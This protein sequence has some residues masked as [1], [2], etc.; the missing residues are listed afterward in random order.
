MTKVKNTE[1]IL[2]IRKMGR[3]N[4]SQIETAVLRGEKRRAKSPSIPLFQRRKSFS[5][6][7]EREVGRDL[8]I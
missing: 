3:L 7:F 8:S 2:R 6:L 5:S 4:F 1:E